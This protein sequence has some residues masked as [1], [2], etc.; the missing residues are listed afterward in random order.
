MRH[1]A[2][3]RELMKDGRTAYRSLPSDFVALRRVRRD[4]EGSRQIGDLERG[5][6]FVK[7]FLARGRFA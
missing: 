3:A 5:G 2:A 7:F 1:F 4:G 6:G